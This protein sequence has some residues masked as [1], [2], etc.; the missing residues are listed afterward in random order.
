M[1]NGLNIFTEFGDDY[2]ARIK[3]ARYQVCGFGDTQIETAKHL[4]LQIEKCADIFKTLNKRR[5]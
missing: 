4:M 2:I 5:K 3:G 1:K